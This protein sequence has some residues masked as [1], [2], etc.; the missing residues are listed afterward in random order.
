[1]TNL[2][3]LVVGSTVLSRT[4]L[5]AMVSAAAGLLAV[6]G[7]GPAGL[8]GQNAADADAA[9]V[10]VSGAGEDGA[11]LVRLVRRE[12]DLPI[13]AVAGAEALAAALS[14]GAD[15]LI[16]PGARPETLAAALRA[17]VEG[18]NVVPRGSLS[19]IESARAGDDADL[20]VERLTPRESEVLQ[21]L[22]AG[23]TNPQMARALGVSEHTIKFHVTAILG[24]LGAGTRAEAV[25]R[26]MRLGWILV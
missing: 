18:L 8:A 5:E 1:M 22:A 6:A 25:G 24:K 17:L 7:A 23:R 13:L 19:S 26:A 3:V 14:A 2:R 21:L 16:E 10:E 15:G 11:G 9:L 20:P 4:G 12:T